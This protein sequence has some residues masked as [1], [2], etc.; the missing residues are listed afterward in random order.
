MRCAAKCFVS[1][2]RQFSEKPLH[3]L[4]AAGRVPGMTGHCGLRCEHQRMRER[5]LPVADTFSSI[6]AGLA[7]RCQ[8]VWPL[9]PLPPS[10]QTEFGERGSP[11][12]VRRQT[13]WVSAQQLCADGIA[14]FYQPTRYGR[15]AN[16][17]PARWTPLSRPS[18]LCPAAV[19]NNSTRSMSLL[20]FDG[21]RCSS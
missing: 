8:L 2:L 19:T 4:P 5:V 13:D 17:H 11:I 16:I 3:L 14:S 10:P 15:A 12:G 9:T 7:L 18:T 21:M 6:P 20:S 1:V